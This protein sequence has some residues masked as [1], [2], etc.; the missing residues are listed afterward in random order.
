MSVYHLRGVTPA[1]LPRVPQDPSVASSRPD[2]MSVSPDASARASL[3]HSLLQAAEQETSAPGGAHT[4]KGAGDAFERLWT[5]TPSDV[6]EKIRKQQ[7]VI[8]AT[9]IE[10][11]I[12]SN[13]PAEDH[14]LA[15]LLLEEM[16]RFASMKSLNGLQ[17]LLV[18]KN[19]Q[20]KLDIYY[21]R[22][23][24]LGS[25]L[26]YLAKKHA[27]LPE[28]PSKLRALQSPFQNNVLKQKSLDRVTRGAILLDAA[29]LDQ[30]A[31]SPALRA[32]VLKHKLRLLYPR[33]WNEGVNPF[34]QLSV[35]GIA[36]KLA[37]LLHIAKQLQQEQGL[38]E[39]Q[40]VKQAVLYPTRSLLAS[41]G[42]KKRLRVLEPGF[43]ASPLLNPTLTHSNRF[44]S[45]DTIVEQ[46]APASISEDDLDSALKKFQQPAYRKG[47]L[48]VLAQQAEIF[49]P[50]RLSLTAQALHLKIMDYARAHQVPAER[51]FYYIPTIAKSY[52]LVSANHLMVNEIPYAQLIEDPAVIENQA[53]SILVVLDDVA[54]SGFSL[55]RAHHS[56]RSKNFSGKIIIAPLVSTTNAQTLL[57]RQ[58]DRNMTYLSASVVPSFKKHPAFQALSPGLQ[59]V[60]CRVVGSLGFKNNGLSLAFPYMTPD[61]NNGFFANQIAPYF[62]LNRAGCKGWGFNYPTEKLGELLQATHEDGRNRQSLDSDFDL[63]DS[64]LGWSD[65]DFESAVS[66]LEEEPD[67]KPVAYFSLGGLKKSPA[68]LNL[69]AQAP[70]DSPER[71]ETDPISIW[72]RTSEWLKRASQSSSI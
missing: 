42:L 28:H 40:S 19:Q 6:V 64:D 3:W 35:E 22:E 38:S 2:T 72:K 69:A 39:E 50:L 41:W 57:E 53:D 55:H 31:Q 13:F 20:K 24:S 60:L 48:E 1:P 8:Q 18:H 49:S 10:D 32:H 21:Q 34:N 58:G 37:K 36:V 63:G 16:T 25:T 15:S 56:I 71:M 5:A 47:A 23:G 17:G 67:Q 68:L 29:T 14:R 43:P 59:Q 54:G 65:S 46:L 66:D 61:N 9:D 26:N 4:T 45:S 51:V 7:A 62:T 33:G 44:P 11:I 70:E 12:V 27:D 30:L 52:G